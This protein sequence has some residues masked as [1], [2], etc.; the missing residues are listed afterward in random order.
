MKKDTLTMEK[1]KRDLG[2][3]N[4]DTTAN[5]IRKVVLLILVCLMVWLFISLCSEVNIIKE[6]ISLVLRVVV[7]VA[8][9]IA[10]CAVHIFKRYEYIAASKK[11]EFFVKKWSMKKKIKLPFFG[12][13]QHSY[14]LNFGNYGFC[15]FD[16]LY[17]VRW[18]EIYQMSA[19]GMFRS[20]EPG[21]VF[22][23][24]CNKRGKVLI[25]YP[26]KLF[27]FPEVDG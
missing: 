10:M 2:M 25:A 17:D 20:S 16:G 7:I 27:E 5:V 6:D 14:I 9:T 18:N 3:L 24:I 23:L 15:Y 13:Y 26:T 4:K 21:E 11:G 1:I 19:S 12:F 22:Y 8:S